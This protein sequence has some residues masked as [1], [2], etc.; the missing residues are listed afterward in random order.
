MSDYKG[1]TIKIV[2]DDDP[3]NPIKEFDTLG[4]MACWHRKYDLGH[5]QIT[6]IDEFLL[7]L[8]REVDPDID[9]K[10]LYWEDGPGWTRLV[11]QEHIA[12]NHKKDEL[13]AY[14]GASNRCDRVKRDLVWRIIDKNY[15]YL[16]LYLYDHSG[17]TMSTSS[18]SCPWDSGQVGYIYISKADARKEFSW[19]KLTKKRVEEVEKCLKS[20]V[21]TYDMWLTGD[22][23]G[24]E[25]YGPDDDEDFPQDSCWGFYGYDYCLQ[26]AKDYVN[27][28]ASE[29]AA[30]VTG[31]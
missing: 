30:D 1:Y 21:E 8:A 16:S 14:T 5:E 17:I 4:T 24:Y 13:S 2:Q 26:E 27:Y 20:V 9:D 22:V 7:G 11:N 19:K 25:I 18:F 12:C 3:A 31:S 23:W 6:D 28:V 10:I 29:E 15:I